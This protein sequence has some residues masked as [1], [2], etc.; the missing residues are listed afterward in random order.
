MSVPIIFNRHLVK[1]RRDRAAEHF[2]E[3]DFLVRHVAEN[4]LDRLYDTHH[5]FPTALE[6]GCHTGQFAKLLKDKQKIHCLI[7]TD[8][9]LAMLKQAAGYRIAM[10]EEWL[11]FKANSIDLVISCMS[12]H[13][14]ND[15]PGTLAQIKQLLKPGGMM[16]IAMPGGATLS[17]LYQSLVATETAF[18]KGVRPHISPFIEV[19]E[20]GQLLQRTGFS[21]PVTDSE[22]LT[23]S[24]KNIYD[25]F[26][27][28]RGM[29]ETN[30]LMKQA[31]GGFSPPLLEAMDCFYREKFSLADGTLKATCEI[32]TLTG[33]K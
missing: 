31:I 6:I 32:V 25:L 11:A 22:T 3:Y 26:R 14:V 28:L 20:A 19:K 2:A 23:I 17:E 21:V 7:Q 10:D 29:G 1:R 9:S 33:I 24:Y 12:M 16:I 27:D 8:T 15:L 30:A 4:I 5:H 13:W 18:G